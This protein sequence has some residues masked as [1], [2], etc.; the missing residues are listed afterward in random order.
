MGFIF[1]TLNKHE[2]VLLWMSSM[3]SKHWPTCRQ[4]W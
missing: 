2:G 4:S 1:V 3:R